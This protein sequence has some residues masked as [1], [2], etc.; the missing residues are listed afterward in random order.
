MLCIK[1][2]VKG[3]LVP[4]PCGQCMP[5]RIN[6]R[7]VW[8]TRLTLELYQHSAACFLT[9]TYAKEPPGGT[10]VKR[11]VQLF[12]KR[13]RKAIYP[14]TVRYY[15]VGE[16]GDNTFRP[17]Y[18]V[19]LYGLDR[20]HARI[21]ADAWGLGHVHVGDVTRESCQYV[22]GYVTKKMNSHADPRLKGR[23]PEFTLMSR[24][25]G[26]GS[27][28]AD[29]I[30]ERMVASS[31]AAGWINQNGDVP[32]VTRMDNKFWPLGRYM[33]SKIRVASGFEN[34][35]SP[36][37]KK[38]EYLQTMRDLRESVGP[39]AFTAAKPFVEWAKADQLIH[40]VKLRTSKRTI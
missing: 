1:P 39:A 17:H 29:Y 30:G 35:N 13:L 5:C 3:G 10:L 9:L 40:R 16:Y 34:G 33:V 4:L 7:R 38:E 15:L 21:F 20:T 31:G 26:I 25:P 14:A 2:F 22:A 37:L 27:K 11:D 32:K 19:V 12:M 28:S 36:P 18:H 8:T 24:N 6:A 23:A